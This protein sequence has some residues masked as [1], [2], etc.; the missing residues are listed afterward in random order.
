MTNNICFFFSLIQETKQDFNT[1][2][3]LFIRLFETTIQ[4]ASTRIEKRPSNLSRTS[5]MNTFDSIENQF[6]ESCRELREELRFNYFGDL[7][8]LSDIVITTDTIAKPPAASLFS[9]KGNPFLNNSSIGKKK[10]ETN[11]QS[12][13]E[14]ELTFN[15]IQSEHASEDDDNYP[16]T[17]PKSKWRRHRKSRNNNISGDEEAAVDT[18]S[19]NKRSSGSTTVA[20][21]STHEHR[22]SSEDTRAEDGKSVN[23]RL[24]VEDSDGEDKHIFLVRKLVSENEVDRLLAQGY[25]FAESVFIAKTM[26]AKLRIPS[27]HMRHH[28]IDMQQMADSICALTQHDWTPS[29]VEP[30]PNPTLFNAS[31]KS[32]VYMGGFVLIDETKDLSNIH[33]VLEKAK[34][35]SFP[36][37]QLKLSHSNIPTHLEPS[38]VEFLFKLQGHSLFDVANLRQTIASLRKQANSEHKLNVFDKVP[39]SRFLSGLES[40]AQQLL[41]TT[42]YNK[43]LFQHS[44]L[45]ASILDLPP[46]SLTTGP[47]QLILFKSFVST[48]GAI[49]AINHTFSESIKCIPLPLYAPLCGFMTDQAATI[50]QANHK[51]HSLPTYLVQQQMYRQQTTSHRDSKK[52]EEDVVIM[53]DT[54]KEDVVEKSKNEDPFSLPPPPRAKRNR[55]KLTSALLNSPVPDTL[56]PLQDG[57]VKTL[58]STRNLKA[59]QAAPLTVLTTQDR[60]WWINS[61]IEETIHSSI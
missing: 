7:G 15:Q 59:L 54:F 47:S 4:K 13:T 30:A 5:T 36:L 53:M 24:S 51:S 32:A 41:E 20:V 11:G 28:F 9:T 58:R 50:Y 6:L 35:Y 25:R 31:T 2:H 60:F 16:R 61:I 55:F 22:S 1:H 42:A 52:M 57:S 17:T 8:I 38:H 23:D 33:I 18:L 10:Y 39:D 14:I 3:P 29:T 21:T 49:A 34:R 12:M 37:A 43:A 26:G 40:A 45:H 46:F 48:Q 56:S 44:K 19:S 27:D